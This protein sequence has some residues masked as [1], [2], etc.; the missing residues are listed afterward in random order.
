MAS[1]IEMERE[2]ERQ[3]EKCA[4]CRTPAPLRTTRLR[5]QYCAE[6]RERETA[7]RRDVVGRCEVGLPG[8]AA[9]LSFAPK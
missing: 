6:K 8:A 9:A 1:E 3:F 4:P 2:R 7:G 5:V